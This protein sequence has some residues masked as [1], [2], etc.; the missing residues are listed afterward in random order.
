MN[1][2]DGPV[3]QITYTAT[4]PEYRYTLT[5]YQGSIAAS[6]EDDGTVDQRLFYD[7]HG[8]RTNENGTPYTGSTGNQNHGYTGH[9][10]DDDTGLINMNG[11][12]FDPTY[13]TFLT[14]DS[15]RSTVGQNANL[16]LYVAGDPIDNTDPTGYIACAFVVSGQRCQNGGGGFGYLRESFGPVYGGTGCGQGP[17]SPA[18]TPATTAPTGALPQQLPTARGLFTGFHQSFL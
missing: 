12:V 13:K 9:E 15:L 8:N 4:I 5:D 2:T 11:R 16:Y 7:P 1:G 14:P 3:G 6:V 18:A 17:A 10:H